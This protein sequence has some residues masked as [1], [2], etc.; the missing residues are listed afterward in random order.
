MR[1]L[2]LLND[3]APAPHQHTQTHPPLPAAAA[4]L[5]EA[6]AIQ[7][8]PYRWAPRLFP[9]SHCHEK[10]YSRYLSPHPWI[11]RHRYRYTEISR[12]VFYVWEWPYE[13]TAQTGTAF[14]GKRTFQTLI[15]AAGF[16]S[17]VAGTTR[18]P[19]PAHGN[20]RFTATPPTAR[21]AINPRSS[22]DAV[23][24]DGGAGEAPTT[25]PSHRVTPGFTE[26]RPGRWTPPLSCGG[27]TQ[28]RGSPSW[29]GSSPVLAS[30]P[31][32]SRRRGTALPASLGPLGT[33]H[34]GRNDPPF[35][36]SDRGAFCATDL[37]AA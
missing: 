8:L 35:S 10:C 15:A 37:T 29:H 1:L 26:N 4:S 27:G 7:L 3:A 11:Q 5:H 32:T 6:H 20:A 14:S 18:S 23:W 16:Y 33:P 21:T 36:G 30:Q 25:A 24:G 13:C 2:P 31:V 34:H 12:D 17:E 19:R 28:Q 9:G 22:P